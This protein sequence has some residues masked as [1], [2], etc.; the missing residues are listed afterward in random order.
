MNQ[1]W[2]FEN[3]KI[4]DCFEDWEKT[5]PLFPAPTAGASWT[6]YGPDELMWNS[7]MNINDVFENPF[8]PND[9]WFCQITGVYFTQTE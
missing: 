3:V 1:T 5:Q 9:P 2:R 8:G 7:N 4:E 6:F